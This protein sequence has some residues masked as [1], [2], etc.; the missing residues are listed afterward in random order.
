MP[1]VPAGSVAP[2]G[3][4]VRWLPVIAA[5][6]LAL[7]AVVA[8]AARPLRASLG[9]RGPLLVAL[10]L[11]GLAPIDWLLAAGALSQPLVEVHWRCGTGEAMLLMVLPF[12]IAGWSVVSMLVATIAAGL[13][14]GPRMERALHR[15]P[16][17]VHYGLDYFLKL[18]PR[19]LVH[20]V[21]GAGLVRGQERQID[22]GLE[23]C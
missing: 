2:V 14:V 20:K 7:L 19:E 21:L 11:I 5:W 1:S 3:A 6:N 10:A 18:C 17:P 13:T 8:L 16:A 22:V 15:L 4:A 9:P 23:H 12:F